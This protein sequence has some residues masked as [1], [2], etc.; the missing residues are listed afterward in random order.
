MKY[1]QKENHNRY[2]PYKPRSFK[3]NSKLT[4]ND[5][6]TRLN[7]LKKCIFNINDSKHM[8]ENK[9]AIVYPFLKNFSNLQG[10]SSMC[11]R[12]FT[13]TQNENYLLDYY[14]HY[15]LDFDDFCR[16]LYWLGQTSFQEFIKCIYILLCTKKHKPYHFLITNFY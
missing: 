15:A 14:F 10:V 6:R 4:L 11:I 3:I 12:R 13:K 7:K 1:I 5:L 9:A 2:N 8:F 16:C